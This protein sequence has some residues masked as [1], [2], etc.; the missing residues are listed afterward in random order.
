MMTTAKSTATDATKK[1]PR[2]A[3]QLTFDDGSRTVMENHSEQPPNLPA[4]SRDESIPI[5]EYFEVDVIILRSSREEAKRRGSFC[6]VIVKIV[7]MI[8]ASCC[9]RNRECPL[10]S[11]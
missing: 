3:P 6:K 7:Y 1:K 4:S 10:R 9:A 11:R 8:K 5:R 2:N